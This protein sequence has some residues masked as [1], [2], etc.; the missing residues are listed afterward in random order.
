MKKT[1]SEDTLDLQE[2]AQ[3]LKMNP[4]V[5]RRKAASAE[6]PGAK[7]GKCWC[8]HKDDLANY[9]R[10][11]YAK[12]ANVSWGVTDRRHTW[13]STNEAKPGGCQSTTLETAYK[14]ALGLPTK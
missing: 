2:A 3:F 11:L 12:P 13:Q 1:L 14:K 8:F 5:L 6:I 10:S 4:E 7:P 9:L